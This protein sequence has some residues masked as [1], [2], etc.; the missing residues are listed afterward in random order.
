MHVSL[1]FL[2]RLFRFLCCFWLYLC[3]VLLILAERLVEKA[4]CFAP[5]KRSCV[6]LDTKLDCFVVESEPTPSVSTQRSSSDRD[7]DAPAEVV[8]RQTRVGPADRLEAASVSKRRAR[9]C[10]KEPSLIRSAA[11]VLN[12]ESAD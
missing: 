9:A 12:S 3:L 7:R 1:S 11:G 10:M 4:E 8:R 6:K 2:V 5:V